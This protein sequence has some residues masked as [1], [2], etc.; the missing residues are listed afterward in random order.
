VSAGA[1]ATPRLRVATYNVHGCVGMDGKRSEARIAEVI[2]SLDVDVIGLQEL[3]LNRRRSAGTDQ[4]GLIAEKL[5]WTRHFH[6]AMRR[7]EEQYGDAILSRHPMNLR[8][9]AALPCAAPFYCRETRGALWV[10]VATP[11]GPVH[12][13]NTHFGLGKRE[14]LLQAQLLTGPD[15]LG[16]VPLREAVVLL[17]DLNS[18]PGS[19]PHRHLATSL[20]D[21]RAPASSPAMAAS[22]PTRWPLFA[23]DHIFVNDALRV[24]EMGVARNAVAAVASDHYP[25]WASLVPVASTGAGD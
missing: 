18:L 16:G 17:G 8:R 7:E 13:F 25:V 6:P 22:F 10:D 4:A 21:A 2:A 19:L 5:S 20:G 3:D 14:R 12:V 23:L 24:E 1:T 15:W 11:I 9:A